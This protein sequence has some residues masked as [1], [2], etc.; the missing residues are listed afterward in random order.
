MQLCLKTKK[1]N[2]KRETHKYVNLIYLI[3]KMKKGAK[4]I[5][6]LVSTSVL[7]RFNSFAFSKTCTNSRISSI[8]II[9]FISV[10]V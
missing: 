1:N 2:L 6:K 7:I 5:S 10:K 3:H 4:A 8:G 9:Q